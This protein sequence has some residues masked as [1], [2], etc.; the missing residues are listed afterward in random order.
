VLSAGIEK[1]IEDSSADLKLMRRI[2]F[3]LFVISFPLPNWEFE[4][5]GIGIFIMTPWAISR[6]VTSLFHFFEWKLVFLTLGFSLGWLANF[7]VFFPLPTW[8][9]W[10]AIT[11]PWLAY[12][13]DVFLIYGSG[14]IDVGML[15][16]IPFYPWAIGIGLI[17]YSRLK[18][19]H[20]LKSFRSSRSDVV[21]G[22]DP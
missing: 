22:S 20:R 7:T 13:T 11:A 12:F 19:T 4:G 18:E 3:Y 8:A 9:R 2:G 16:F 10:T 15:T 5:T 17:N 1:K 21:A 14:K 6:F